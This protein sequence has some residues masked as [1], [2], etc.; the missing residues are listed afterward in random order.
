MFCSVWPPSLAAGEGERVWK[1]CSHVL[2][3]GLW[4]PRQK[5]MRFVVSNAVLF[6]EVTEQSEMRNRTV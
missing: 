6:T 3:V 2:V 5:R 4:D 1:I